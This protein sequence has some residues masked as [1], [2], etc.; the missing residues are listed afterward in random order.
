MIGYP[1]SIKFQTVRSEQCGWEKVLSMKHGIAVRAALS[2]RRQDGSVAT[3]NMGEATLT[4]SE[5]S[6]Q[7]RPKLEPRVQRSSSEIT[8]AVDLVGGDHAPEEVFQGVMLAKQENPSLQVILVGPQETA[9]SWLQ[10]TR[11]DGIGVEAAQQ[12]I[13]MGDEPARAVKLK[14][15]ASIVV[16]TRLVGMG[17]AQAFV[18]AGNTG[19]VI[20]ASLLNMG[21]IRGIARPAIAVVLPGLSRPVVLLDAGAT[22]DCKPAYLVQFAKMA[23]VFA[24]TVLKVPAPRIGLLNVGEEKS[25]GSKL[26]QRVYHHLEKSDLPFEGNVEGRD[27]IRGS[28]DIVVTDGFTGNVLLKALEGATETV[29]AE[30]NRLADQSIRSRT[31]GW[32]LLPAFRD[33][34]RRLHYE[35]YGGAQLLG[36]RGVCIIAHGQSKA[37]AI[38]N[39]LLLAEKTARS[40]I[41]A[42]I[43]TELAK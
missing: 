14:Q 25:K 3:A 30:V 28:T 4:E 9:D 5:E 36:V 40:G 10:R 13:N 41:V 39:A 20:A 16:G 37:R 17:K 22:V 29:F 19:A 26:V 27:I 33:L 23:Y 21:R 38:K 43:E 42:K 2:K 12:V 11:L 15:D 1:W 6:G 32:L 31:G 35:E 34:K 7:E 24:A 18:S 8:V